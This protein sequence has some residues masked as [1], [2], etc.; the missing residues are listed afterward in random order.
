MDSI[1]ELLFQ[2]RQFFA[3]VPEER[4]VFAKNLQEALTS[5]KREK[6]VVFSGMHY[7]EAM[8][9]AGF[10]V[11]TGIEAEPE[12]ETVEKMAA[13]L[14]EKNPDEVIAIGGGSVLDAAK[15]AWLMVQTGWSLD[16]L[17]GVN[18]WSSV[19]P[20]KSLKRQSLSVFHSLLPLLPFLKSKLSFYF[21]FITHTRVSIIVFVSFISF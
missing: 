21:Y 10:T 1:N 17:F 14:L 4:I 6:C 13:F 11:F 16:E 18:R 8:R 12:T 5:F 20:G 15:A 2:A 19:N 3:G 9:E 7:A